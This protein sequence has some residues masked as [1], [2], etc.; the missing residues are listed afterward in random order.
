MFSA[1]I[2]F[3]PRLNAVVSFVLITMSSHR[4]KRTPCG[5]EGAGHRDEQ[6]FSSIAPLSPYGFPLPISFP[7]PSHPDQLVAFER[8]FFGQTEPQWSAVHSFSTLYAQT[9][10]ATHTRPPNC[11]VP[12]ALHSDN[13]TKEKGEYKGRAV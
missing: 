2:V 10:E 5:R 8:C 12:Y 7:S 4:C 13:S 11:N 6:R 9:S 1:L 3:T